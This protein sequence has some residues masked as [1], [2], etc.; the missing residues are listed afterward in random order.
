VDF[1]LE[2]VAAGSGVGIGSTSISE[3]AASGRDWKMLDAMSIWPVLAEKKHRSI[4]GILGGRGVTDSLLGKLD[5]G[6]S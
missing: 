1:L 3:A 6:P 4:S 2:G 5:L